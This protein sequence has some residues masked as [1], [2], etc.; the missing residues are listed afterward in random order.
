MV[1]GVIGCGNVGFAFLRW[2]HERGYRTL[3]FDV[4]ESVRAKISKVIGSS[5]CADSFE[6]LR[7]CD[8]IFICVPTEPCIDGSVD[9]SIFDLTI[10]R[11][12]DNLRFEKRVSVIQRSTCLP[13]CAEYY[14]SMLG[15][16]ISYGVNP[17]FLRKSTIQYDTERPDRVAYAATGLARSHLDLIYTGVSGSRYIS[18]SYKSVELLKYAENTLDGLLISYWN[19]LLSYAKK[20]SLSADEFI[21]LIEHIG[22]R[23]K[24]CTVARIP[25]KA[26]SLSCIPKDLLGLVIEMKRLGVKPNVLEGAL[27]T[28]EAIKQ[29]FGDS[30]SPA[31][32]LWKLYDGRF[33]T[34]NMGRAQV[35]SFFEKI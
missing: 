21:N 9:M 27:E 20:I 18:E 11:I 35:S 34:L 12:R 30:T 25:G 16:N 6:T 4:S 33:V 26:F 3:G 2:L 1:I 14:S 15:D 23:D 31:Q 5:S 28:N 17:S 7:V 10:R 29:E 8:C 22:D 32:D 24:F 13:G 19:E